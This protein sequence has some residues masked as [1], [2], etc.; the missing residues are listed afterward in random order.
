MLVWLKSTNRNS[1]WKLFH[2]FYKAVIKLSHEEKVWFLPIA[3]LLTKKVKYVALEANKINAN[4]TK[5]HLESAVNSV[6]YM[7]REY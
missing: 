1:N 2:E 7:L 6:K 3:R 5:N 4:N